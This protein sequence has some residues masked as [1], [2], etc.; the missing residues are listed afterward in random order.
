MD[1]TIGSL[2]R[3]KGLA[4]VGQVNPQKRSQRFSR[5]RYVYIQDL[6]I[7]FK[8]LAYNRSARFAAAAGND[9]FF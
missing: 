8:Q 6:I 9:D 3:L 2:Q 4:Q 5:G 1:D 7:V